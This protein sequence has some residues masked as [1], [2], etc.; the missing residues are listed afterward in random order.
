MQ[1]NETLV[2]ERKNLQTNDRGQLKDN[3]LLIFTDTVSRSRLHYK[4][5]ETAKFFKEKDHYE[6]FRHHSMEVRTLENGLLFMYGLTR[7]DLSNKANL[8]K[9]ARDFKAPFD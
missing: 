6:F 2:E 8:P 3:L 7:D 9:E 5:P 1:R 4:L